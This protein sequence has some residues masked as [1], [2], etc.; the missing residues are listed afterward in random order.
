MEWPKMQLW[1]IHLT[2]FSDQ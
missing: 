1:K 2:S